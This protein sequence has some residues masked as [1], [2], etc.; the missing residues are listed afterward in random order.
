MSVCRINKE[1]LIKSI[2]QLP[3]TLHEDGGALFYLDGNGESIDVGKLRSDGGVDLTFAPWAITREGAAQREKNQAL[4]DD[5]IA[6]AKAKF[7]GYTSRLF[8]IDLLDGRE[9]ELHWIGRNAS[10]E[11]WLGMDNGQFVKRAAGENWDENDVPFTS[12]RFYVLSS[13][14][15]I[16]HW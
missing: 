12:E 11:F 5:I 4:F 16:G 10:H 6:E 1:A 7:D 13:P 9:V 8:K 3:D 2:E 14:G 15:Y